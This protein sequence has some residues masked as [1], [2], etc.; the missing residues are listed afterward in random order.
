MTPQPVLVSK[1]LM[2]RPCQYNGQAADL[3]LEPAII[4][5]LGLRVI[6]VC[7][8]QLAGLPTPRVPSEIFGGNGFDVLSGKARV[9]NRE[10]RDLTREFIE[11]ARKTLQMARKENA[12]LMITRRRSPSC[13]SRQVYDGSFSH[14]LVDGPGVTVALLQSE[15][16]LKSLDLEELISGNKLSL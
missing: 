2:G 7:P 13:G 11:G 6:E 5:G 12:V 9:K 16:N 3:L 14:R 4:E 8:E 10:G 1:C 15:L